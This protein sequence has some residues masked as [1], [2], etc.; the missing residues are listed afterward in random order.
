M[1]FKKIVLLFMCLSI[2]S[3]SEDSDIPIPRNLQEYIAENSNVAQKSV[4]ACA[5][6]AEA[7]TRLTYIFYYPEE[8]ASDIR[9]Y[10]LTDVTLDKNN[11]TNYRRESLA[12]EAVFGGKLERFSRPGAS[13]NWC[14]V[15][16]VKE[17][18]LRISEPIKLN[19]TSKPTT[20]TDEVII[21][22][23]TTSEPNFNW[24]DDARNE[25]IIYFQVFTDE[26][27]AFISGTYTEDTFF[28]YYDESNVLEFPKIN[29]DVPQDLEEDKIYN[30]TMLG[31]NEDNWVNLIIEEQFIPRNLEE[32]VAVNT[33]KTLASAVAFGGSANGNKEETYIYFYPIEGAFEYR[34]YE[35]ENT[36]VN[37]ADFSNYKRINLTAT[38]QFDGKFRR[39]S[40][41]SS[42][43]VWCLVTYISNGK[44]HI[45]DP[46]KTKNNSKPTEWITEVDI[47][48]P[49]TLKPI[50]TWEDG[51]YAENETYFQV[52]TQNDDTFLSGTFTTEKTF[53]YNN[54]S[55]VISKIHT[56]DPPNL[57]LDANYKFFLYGLSDDNWINLVIE[58]T[59]IAQ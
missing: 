43:Q 23:K 58:N 53:Q 55:N 2:F 19:N 17:G 29:S 39:F 1:V 52:I 49:E 31:V 16:Y 50:F 40:H 57:V 37:Q 3:C 45:S 6:N 42:D 4:V 7:N 8:G 35:T 24:E 51:I 18:V 32:Y 21:N 36:T 41:D 46:I 38:P 47:V 56:E 25:S 34:Y 33:D 54:E 20:Y 9:Y 28:Q 14:L 48:Y 15:T 26:E 27:D 59:F 12:S 30:F 5:A 22:Y 11:F 44:L 10:E 13:E